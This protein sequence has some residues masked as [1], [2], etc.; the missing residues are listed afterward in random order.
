M[1]NAPHPANIREQD[2]ETPWLTRQAMDFIADP[3]R[4]APWMYHLSYI[5][6]HWA[7]IVPAPWHN[8]YGP[9]DILPANRA[10]WRAG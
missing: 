5:K 10:P 6:P 8:L 7:S 3:A 1:Q 9:A 2:S 4:K